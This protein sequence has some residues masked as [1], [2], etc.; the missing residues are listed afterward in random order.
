MNPSD[1][2]LLLSLIEIGTRAAEAIKNIRDNNPEAYA[3]VGKH[4]ADALA[5]LEAATAKAGS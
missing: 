2:N 5:R 1:V 4:H 3:Q